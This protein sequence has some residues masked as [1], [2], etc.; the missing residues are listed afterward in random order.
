MKKIGEP[1]SN[2]ALLSVKGGNIPG[3]NDPPGDFWCECYT[4]GNSWTDHFDDMNSLNWSI[5]FYCNPTGEVGGGPYGYCI[6][7]G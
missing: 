4:Y 1:I 3:P 6:K 7:E 5:N 2:E